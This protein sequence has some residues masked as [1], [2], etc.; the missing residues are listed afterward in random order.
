MK[1]ENPLERQILE[2]ENLLKRLRE[3]Y[4]NLFEKREELQSQI[5]DF[6]LQLDIYEK[7]GIISN[8]EEFVMGLKESFEI[9]DKEKFVTHLLKI[10]EPLV[11]AKFTQ[12]RIFEKIQREM[13]VN[14]G[15]KLS[16]VL[17]AELKPEDGIVKI[18]LA[19]AK[20]LIKGEGV[21]YF[22][23]EIEI[24]LRKLAEEIGIPNNEI[25]KIVAE[26]WIVAKNRSLVETLGFTYDG[27][28]PKE[29]SGAV[30]HDDLGN[31]LPV[32]RAVMT[33]E[34]FLV[35]YGIKK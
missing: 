16:E 18:H 17:S 31:K 27:I 7:E 32:A 26:S 10:F 30:Y 14:S 1:L 35:R 24:G 25:K 19:P 34:D 23:K 20:E 5:E 15:L 4:G 21:G 2:K 13:E 6:I 8:K 28:L 33:R 22:K 11:N 3:K 12:P 29:E 9:Q